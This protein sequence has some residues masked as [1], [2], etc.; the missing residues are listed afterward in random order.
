[1]ITQKLVP[2]PC[3]W[4]CLGKVWAMSERT[5]VRPESG[6]DFRRAWRPVPRIGTQF[7]P[8]GTRRYGVM[9]VFYWKGTKGV[10]NL[11]RRPC[12]MPAMWICLH[13]S[14]MSRQTV[15]QQ[16]PTNHFSRLIKHPQS[17]QSCTVLLIC[18]TLD[19]L[20]KSSIPN[21]RHGIKLT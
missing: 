16:T 1:M 21:W 6:S 2:G 17:L 8:S 4:T 19:L 7:G 18:H 10:V 13:T 20:G 9:G 5:V 15:Q 12:Q 14:W 11:P 3:C